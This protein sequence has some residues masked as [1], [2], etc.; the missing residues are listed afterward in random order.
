MS[1]FLLGA[2]SLPI[3]TNAAR[4][5]LETPQ[6]TV[7]IGQRFEVVLLIHSEGETINAPAKGVRANI[8]T[9]IVEFL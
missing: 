6:E 2:F 5:F 1:V 4:I 8:V 7:G 3:Q 9:K